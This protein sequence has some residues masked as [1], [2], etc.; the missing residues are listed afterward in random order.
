MRAPVGIRLISSIELKK[1]LKNVAQPPSLKYSLNAIFPVTPA[2]A[3]AIACTLPDKLLAASP[4]CQADLTRSGGFARGG[5][6]WGSLPPNM[7]WLKDSSVT[8]ARGMSNAANSAD[9]FEQT[10]TIR[11]VD[12]WSSPCGARQ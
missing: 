3:F 10:N 5:S 11:I 12:T 2:A 9:G 1:T 6:S 4:R 8:L 7:G